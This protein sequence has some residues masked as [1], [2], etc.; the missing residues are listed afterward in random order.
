MSV[1]MM[2]GQFVELVA[3][4]RYHRERFQLYRA[5]IQGDRTMTVVRLRELARESD[6]AQHQLRAARRGV[7]ETGNR[8]ES[9]STPV[10]STVD[11]RFD[12]NEDWGKRENGRIPTKGASAAERASAG[13]GTHRD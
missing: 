13:L 12:E 2:D 8:D 6:Q 5:G 3:E 1:E 9:K 7:S 10:K 11:K 4:A